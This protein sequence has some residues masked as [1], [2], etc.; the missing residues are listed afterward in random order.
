MGINNFPITVDDLT[1]A[2]VGYTA[3]FG[4]GSVG[5]VVFAPNDFRQ[6][7]KVFAALTH[8]CHDP[9]FIGTAQGLNLP[10]AEVYSLE[11]EQNKTTAQRDNF[12]NVPRFSHDSVRIK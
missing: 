12:P 10:L 2:I 4:G 11:N 7:A 6:F 1:T 3:A 9:V 5:R 8:L